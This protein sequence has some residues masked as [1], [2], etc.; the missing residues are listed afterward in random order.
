MH[1]LP[2]RR[3]N[4]HQ[5]IQREARDSALQQVI[6]VRLR[7]AAV[8]CGFGPCPAACFDQRS[9]LAH[10]FGAY[11]QVCRVFAG[12]GN[13]VPDAREAVEP[14]RFVHDF[15][16]TAGLNFPGSGSKARR[17]GCKNYQTSNQLSAKSTTASG[18][19]LKNWQSRHRYKIDPSPDETGL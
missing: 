6:D 17:S 15:L 11:A 16:Q 19:T 1:P 3:S 7:D 8:T 18:L 14:F 2:Q 10:Q 13:G 9:D 12:V 4:V 5:S